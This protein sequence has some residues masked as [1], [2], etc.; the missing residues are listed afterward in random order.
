MKEIT[1]MG[2]IKQYFGTPD[3]P[4]T[5]D[6]LKALSQSDRVELAE[7]AAKELGCVLKK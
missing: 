3:H 5:M 2:A 7:G 6:E 4:V 1:K